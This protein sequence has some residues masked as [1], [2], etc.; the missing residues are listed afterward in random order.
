VT[1]AGL[2][3]AGGEP[4]AHPDGGPPRV[5]RRGGTVLRPAAPWTPAVHA[6]LRYLEQ[7]GFAGAP[8]VVGDGYDGHGREVLTYIEGSSVHPH[9]WSDEGIWQVG[10]LLRELHDATAGFRP[11]RGASWYPSEFRT[12]FGEPGTVV[13]HGDTGPWNIAATDG[14][15]T[16]FFDWDSAGPTAL[17]DEVAA[18]AWLNAQLHDDDVAERQGLPP[19]AV[20]AAQLRHFADGYQLPAAGRAGLVTAMTE[21]AIRDCAAEAVKGGVTPDSADP[22]PLWALAWRARSAAWLLRHRG[23]LENAI[24]AGR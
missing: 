4:L 18:T 23:L 9:P 20:R 8:R 1:G 2:P 5:F 16:A 22:A 11:P 15:P 17:I 12:G 13:S 24:T 14:R 7:A 6:L 10:R 21:Y 19:A 3:V